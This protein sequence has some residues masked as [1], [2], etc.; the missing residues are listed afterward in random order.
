MY[1]SSFFVNII[2][3][4]FVAC[5]K[6]NDEATQTTWIRTHVESLFFIG[7]LLDVYL[8]IMT[9]YGRNLAIVFLKSKTFWFENKLQEKL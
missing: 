2:I 7:R 6:Q 8:R 4:V 5:H 9:I 3:I 1:I